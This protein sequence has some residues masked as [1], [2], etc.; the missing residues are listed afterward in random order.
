MLAPLV[1][2]AETDVLAFIAFPPSTGK[3]PPDQSSRT[4][5]QRGYDDP[6]V[7]GIFLDQ[8]R[9]TRLFGAILIRTKRRM[10]RNTAIDIGTM[11]GRRGADQFLAVPKCK[12]SLIERRNR[13]KIKTPS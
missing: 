2:Q 5:Q 1:D 6:H 10:A 8:A 13:L 3:A 9:I 4:S 12:G 11:S 7:V